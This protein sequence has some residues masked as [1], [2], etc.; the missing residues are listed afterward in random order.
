MYFVNYND[1][2]EFCNKLTT[3]GHDEGWLPKNWKFTLPTEAQWEYACRAGTTTPFSYGSRSDIN[4]MN[5][6]SSDPYG[7]GVSG[8]PRKS[9]V[10]VGSLGYKNAL[11]LYDMHGNVCEWCLDH[12]DRN[13]YSNEARDPLCTSGS[14]RVVRGG[15]WC[16]LARLCRSA[17][18][19]I[20]NPTSRHDGVGFRLALVPS[21]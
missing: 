18:R 21:Q 19:D 16:Y 5:F 6:W 3:R 4:K 7:G 17:G 14:G 11:G 15:G 10:E 12:Y 8:T 1:A 13:F 9:T 20:Y 2:L